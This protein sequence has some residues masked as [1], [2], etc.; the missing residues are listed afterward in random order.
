MPGER[1][2]RPTTPFPGQQAR[3]GTD[4]E[5]DGILRHSEHWLL[6]ITP[7][8]WMEHESFGIFYYL[9]WLCSG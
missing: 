1:P 6:F 4:S 8:R 2:P 5:Q 3:V 7:L 9:G